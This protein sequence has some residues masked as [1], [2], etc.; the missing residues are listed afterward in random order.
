MDGFCLG[1]VHEI[2]PFFE[3]ELEAS[4]KQKQRQERK[5]RTRKKTRES[6]EKRSKSAEGMRRGGKNDKDGR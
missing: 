3:P 1:A 5:Q 4:L 2:G 6:R